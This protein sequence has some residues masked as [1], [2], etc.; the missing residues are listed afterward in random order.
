MSYGETRPKEGGNGINEDAIISDDAERLY[1]VFDGMGGHDAGEI[2]SAEAV[3]AVREAVAQWDTVVD[4]DVSDLPNS[5]GRALV[6]AHRAVRTAAGGGNMG[7]TASVAKLVERSDGTF[8]AVVSTVGDSPAYVWRAEA[9][10]LELVGGDDDMLV[11]G[12]LYIRLG[13][14]LKPAEAL[15]TDEEIGEIRRE[16]RNATT[17][18]ELSP[19]AQELW[20]RR[21]IVGQNLGNEDHEPDPRSRLVELAKGDK[22]LLMS[23]GISDFV[24]EQDIASAAAGTRTPKELSVLLVESALATSQDKAQFRTTGKNPD[25]LSVVVVQIS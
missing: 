21:N 5:L 24:G 15:P 7:T 25:D 8:A 12:E 20:K 13:L 4:E 19:R 22:L 11:G 3:K 14:G 10:T 6:Q 2:A 17:E 16:I 23:D 1:G 18:A 9:K